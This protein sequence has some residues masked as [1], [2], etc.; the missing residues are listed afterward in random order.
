MKKGIDLK[1]SASGY[2]ALGNIYMI[3]GKY[4]ECLEQY[5][6]GQNIKG[7]SVDEKAKIWINMALLYDKKRRCLT[8][9]VM[10]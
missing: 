8:R 3:T 9:R 7:A 4:K 5:S 2:N 1:P 10:S 6:A